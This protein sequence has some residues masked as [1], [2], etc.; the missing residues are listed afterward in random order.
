VS[1]GT[2]RERSAQRRNGRSNTQ[3]DHAQAIKRPC[4]NLSRRLGAATFANAPTYVTLL[5]GSSRYMANQ[6]HQ[7][8]VTRSVSVLRTHSRSLG[9]CRPPPTLVRCEFL[10]RS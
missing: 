9:T 3:V 5:R 6:P 4:D 8:P 1:A 2:K 10:S 7:H